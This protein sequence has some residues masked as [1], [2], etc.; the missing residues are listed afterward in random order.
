MFTRT[1]RIY[2]V[3]AQLVERIHGRAR[4]PARDASNC[5]VDTRITVKIRTQDK[6]VAPLKIDGPERLTREPSLSLM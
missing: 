6:T 3:L 1:L 2:A 5:I 4:A